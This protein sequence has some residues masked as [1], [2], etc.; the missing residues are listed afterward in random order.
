MITVVNKKKN[1]RG[2]IYAGRPGPYGNPYVVGV[3]GKRGDCV[4]AFEKFLLSDKGAEFREKI[5]LIPDDAV[6]ECFCVPNPCHAQVIADYENK[7]RGFI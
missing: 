6:L 1:Q 4:K 5:A 3:H 2:T 7:R